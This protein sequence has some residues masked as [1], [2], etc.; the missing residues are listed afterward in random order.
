[1]ASEVLTCPYCNASIGVQPGMAAG[2]RMGCPRCGDAFTLPRL[3]A[4]TDRPHA[5][6]APQTAITANPPAAVPS[7]QSSWLIAGAVVGVMLVMAGGGLAFMLMTKEQRRAYDTN[8]PERRPGRQP[9]MPEPDIAPIA[10][11]APDKLAALGYLPAGTNFLIAA[12]IVELL[13]TPVGTQVLR[14]PLRLGG[15]DYRLGNLPAWVGL[16]LEDIDHLVFAAKLNDALIPPF[17]LVLRTT[18]PY[19]DETMRQRL[20]GTRVASASKKKLCSFRTPKNDFTLHTWFAD[21]R[22]LVVS[23]FSDQLESL[24]AQPAEDLRQLPDEVRTVL[25]ERREPVAPVWIVGHSR[26]WMKTTA[27]K[28]LGRMKKEDLQ[29]LTAIETFGLWLVPGKALDV[30]G[31][32]ACKNPKAARELGDYFRALRGPDPNFKT[33]LDGPWLSLQYQTDP[34]FLSR[35]LKR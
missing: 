34:D 35:L 29:R 33:A 30:K 27:G 3:D 7:R 25:K 21:D 28:F 20:K 14:N 15:S 16:R 17:Y 9:G 5:P 8:R 18:Q 11:V 12:R 26:D 13:D 2:Q 10:S 22:T 24:P 32:F 6:V 4:F 1:M 31:V 19:D 23:L